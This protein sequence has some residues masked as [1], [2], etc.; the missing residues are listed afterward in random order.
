MNC[1]IFL[2]VDMMDWSEVPTKDI[3]TIKQAAHNSN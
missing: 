2:K 3:V 1:E